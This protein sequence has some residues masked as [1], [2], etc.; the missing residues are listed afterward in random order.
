[1]NIT[2]PD[3]TKT[4]LRTIETEIKRLNE[5]VGSIITTICE[6]NNYSGSYRITPNLDIETVD[7]PDEDKDSLTDNPVVQKKTKTKTIVDVPQKE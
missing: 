1:M 3:A 6:V 5:I 4:R 7:D 2:V